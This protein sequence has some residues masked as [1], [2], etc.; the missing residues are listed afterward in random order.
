[1][2]DRLRALRAS[3]GAK[4]LKY[5]GVSA[6]AIAVTQVLLFV[7]LQ[8]LDMSPAWSNFV[9]VSLASI[10]AY[11]LNRQWVWAKTGRHSVRREVLPFWGISLLG[12]L[13]S[14]GAVAL[15]SRWTHAHL[16]IAATNIASFGLLWIGKFF[17][18]DKLMFGPGQH[19]AD[20]PVEA[21][22]AATPTGA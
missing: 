2:I 22:V 4:A 1:M 12:L 19:E 11:L 8:I 15:V 14:T 5:A 6:I 7:T 13:I 16:V 3:H 10:P 9:S 20:E 17:Y 21:D 18:L